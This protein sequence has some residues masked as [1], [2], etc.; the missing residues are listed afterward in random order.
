MPLRPASALVLA[1]GRSARFGADKALALFRGVPLLQHALGRVKSAFAQ[2]ALVAKQP[3]NYAALAGAGVALVEDGSPLQ[4]PLAGLAAGLR[5]SPLPVAF[6]CAVDMPFAADAALLDALFASLEGHDA[7]VP[8]LRGELQ[9]LC[10]LWRREPALHAAGPL[11]EAGAG[12]RALFARLRTAV[13]ERDDERPFLDADT[14]DE[15]ARLE[16]MAARED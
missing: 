10:S 12:P 1:G 15:L 2:V 11:L 8:S 16:Q 3:R 7:A 14:R 4:T 9:P 5:W 6:L 13:V